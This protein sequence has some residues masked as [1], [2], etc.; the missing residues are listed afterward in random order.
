MIG[1]APTDSTAY[2]QMRRP[3]P[4]HSHV[5]SMRNFA[6]TVS[7]V[8]AGSA[9][10]DEPSWQPSVYPDNQL[11]SSYLVSTAVMNLPKEMQASW[12]YPHLGDDQSMIG[13]YVDDLAKGDKVTVEV[14]KTPYIEGGKITVKV[15]KDGSYLVHPRVAYDYDALVR[16]HQPRPIN[17]RIEVSV[18]G[19][20]LGEQMQTATLHSINDC[21]FAIDDTDYSYLFA[22]YVNEDHPWVDRIL[23]D[24]LETGIVDAF[25]G[26]QSGDRDEV[27]KQIY[28]IW[29]VMQRRGMKYSSITAT[30]A[31]SESTMSQH[32]RLF[33]HAIRAKQANCV[34][35]SVL[36]AAVL[37][38]IGLDV[39]LVVL[40]AHMYLAV[41]LDE[42][43]RIRFGRNLIGLETTMMGASDEGT[44]ED[45]PIIP[46][47]MRAYWGNRTSWN[48]FEGAVDYATNELPEDWDK[49][50]SEDHP[51][52]QIIDIAEAR[53]YG[54]LPIVSADESAIEALEDEAKTGE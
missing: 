28:A 40:P 9:L 32:V 42:K 23:R 26:Y 6:L 12:D 52:Y 33:D 20:S 15:P 35:G 34:D 47:I 4:G 21:L 41:S 16:V 22:S 51:D 53:E 48:S 24:A 8:L 11:Y 29:D 7:L 31:R 3:A 5:K 1:V 49:A 2:F 14:K 43:D 46:D 17:V 27:L 19:E 25:D 39:Y 10:A 18:N 54:I 45:S 36:L 13:A 44:I 37:R 50:T 38:K 30:S